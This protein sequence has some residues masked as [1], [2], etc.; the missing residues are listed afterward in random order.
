MD[1]VAGAGSLI[2][3]ALSLAVQNNE[4]SVS[5][6]PVYFGY[7]SQLV[8]V[9]ALAR[10]TH[11]QL[12]VIAPDIF[13]RIAEKSEFIHEL[14]AWIMHRA[15]A[16]AQ[17]WRVKYPNL[18][19][20]L[21]VNVSGK[22][23]H[24]PGFVDRV[25]KILGDT[26]LPANQLQIE[27]AESVFLMRPGPTQKVLDKIRQLGVRVALDGFGTGFSS[28]G[29]I[30]R[31]PIDALKVDR[32]FVS[33][34]LLSERDLAIVKCVL[35][36]GEKLGLAVTAEGIETRE[37]HELLLSMGCLYFQGYYFNSPMSFDLIS[38]VIEKF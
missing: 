5:Y 3:D 36:L 24:H 27:A 11:P 13:I 23:L 30:D 34:M 6:Q 8:G 19:L 10:W 14:G 32:Y 7:D 1:K 25:I 15:C 2:Q 22:E 21:R 9:E 33:R 28:L 29:Y 17:A 38:D 20:R 26:G 12:G 18:L 37:Q 35:L 31:Y 4:L 16:D